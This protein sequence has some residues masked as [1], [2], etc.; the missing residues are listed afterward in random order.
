MVT[1]GVKKR[2]KSNLRVLGRKNRQKEVIE[3]DSH[4]QKS[5]NEKSIKSHT[6]QVDKDKRVSL[7]NNLKRSMKDMKPKVNLKIFEEFP[8]YSLNNPNTATNKNSQP[9]TNFSEVN[10]QNTK[11]KPPS[12]KFKITSRDSSHSS[13]LQNLQPL[14]TLAN[15]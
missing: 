4:E 1:Q 15:S 14:S 11:D 12:L 6:F 2:N 5:E 3:L 10:Q 7:K 8:R 9:I 13:K